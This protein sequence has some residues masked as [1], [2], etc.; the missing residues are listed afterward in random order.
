MINRTIDDL[1]ELLLEDIEE[2]D[3]LLIW[4]ESEKKTKKVSIQTLMDYLKMINT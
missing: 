2:F 3:T 1:E 4:D